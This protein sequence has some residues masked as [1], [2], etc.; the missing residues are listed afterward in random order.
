MVLIGLCN[1]VSFLPPIYISCFRVSHIPHVRRA[2][3]KVGA[4]GRKVNIRDVVLL[5]ELPECMEEI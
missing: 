1:S 4:D 2:A 5:A 3:D